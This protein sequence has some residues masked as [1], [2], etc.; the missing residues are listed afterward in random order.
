MF[1]EMVNALKPFRS[2]EKIC[3]NYFNSVLLLTYSDAIIELLWNV[4]YVRR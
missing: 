3:Q 2:A 4:M 1:S